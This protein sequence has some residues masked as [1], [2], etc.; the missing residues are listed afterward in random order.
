MSVIDQAHDV[1][2]TST[3]QTVGW[4]FIVAIVLGFF[5]QAG[6]DV[7]FLATVVALGLSWIL[8]SSYGR[9]QAY[10]QIEEDEQTE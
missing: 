9:R 7:T 10:E 4:I 6:S 5:S 1:L 8:G 2:A 3:G